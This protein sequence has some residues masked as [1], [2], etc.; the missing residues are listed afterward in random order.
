MEARN[1]NIYFVPNNKNKVGGKFYNVYLNREEQLDLTS[2]LNSIVDISELEDKVKEH[3][4]TFKIAGGIIIKQDESI[5][6]A[7]I[8]KPD[9]GDINLNT[10]QQDAYERW[11]A[12]D[13]TSNELYEKRKKDMEEFILLQRKIDQQLEQIQ[14]EKNKLSEQIN[15]SFGKVK[16]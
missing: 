14:F 6:S 9:N 12:L 16:K 3:D 8:Y 5:G 11:I 15:K 13:K 2:F 10:E 1:V 4:D 7:T